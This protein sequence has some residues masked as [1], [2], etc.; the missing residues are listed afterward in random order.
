MSALRAL[1]A[2]ALSLLVPASSA[3]D[4]RVRLGHFDS[5]ASAATSSVRKAAAQ[6]IAGSPAPDRPAGPQDRQCRFCQGRHRGHDQARRGGP[7]GRPARLVYVVEEGRHR[8]QDKRGDAD[9][10][11]PGSSGGLG[12]TYRAEAA[13]AGGLP[14]GDSVDTTPWLTATLTD[15]FAGS[16][17]APIWNQRGRTTSPAASASARRATRG[18]QG[19]RWHP[20][21]Q[22]HQGPSASGKARP[23][24]ARR[25]RSDYRL[26]GHVGT[27]IR[28]QVRRC[29]R[30]HQDAQ[31]A[32]PARE[33][34]DAAGRREPR[35]RRPRDRRHRVLR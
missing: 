3:H 8:Q 20:A 1:G 5:A 27:T 24:R 17:L 32:R 26:N 35:R 25:R 7:Q 10:A 6:Q 9:F 4:D 29:R 11:V 15:E 28:L 14:S 12:I 21:P 18:R 31:A 13:K 33:L 34:L 30:P 23:R 2:S 22:R 19:H 16:T